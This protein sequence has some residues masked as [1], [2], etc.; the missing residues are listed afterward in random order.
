MESRHELWNASGIR[1]L[2]LVAMS[3]HD[4]WRLV[5]ACAKEEGKF[6]V[7]RVGHRT[8]YAIL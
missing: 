7:F 1:L 3:V 4:L 8:I 6:D 2:T 5:T